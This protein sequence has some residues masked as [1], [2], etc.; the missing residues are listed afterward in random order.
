MVLVDAAP[1]P[2]DGYIMLDLAHTMRQKRAF[3]VQNGAA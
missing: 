2:R 3:P 1:L